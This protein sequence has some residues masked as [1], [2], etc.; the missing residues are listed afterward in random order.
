MKRLRNVGT[1][2]HM[3]IF[4]RSHVRVVLLVLVGVVAV[5]VGAGLAL[6][7]NKAAPIGTGVVVIETNLAYQNAAAAGT[8]MVLTSSG[9]VLT[10]NHVIAGATTVKVV[11]PGTGKR[12][13]AQVV[14]YN[15]TADVAE[16]RLQ[17]ASN[18]KTVSIGNSAKVT[19]GQAVT[20]LGNAGGTGKLTSAKGT[21]TGLGKSITANDEQGGVRAADRAHRDEREHPAGRLR[22]TA[23][24]PRGSRD[25]HGHGRLERRRIPD[26]RRDDRRLCDPDRQ[27][28]GRSRSRSMQARRRRPSTS[29]TRRSSASR[30]R[31]CPATASATPAPRAR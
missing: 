14:G 3:N 4:R 13:T 18:L 11:V 12:Y 28:A 9:E 26:G 2:G 20:A 7:D 31:P 30:S 29:A 24:R 21:V 23:A 5:A 16:L 1:T 8:G 25:R 6:A 19:V 27:G 15:R 22:W 10:N 17:G